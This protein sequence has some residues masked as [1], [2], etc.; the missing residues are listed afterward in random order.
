MGVRGQMATEPVR[1]RSAGI[2]LLAAG[3]VIVVLAI[4]TLAVVILEAFGICGPSSSLSPS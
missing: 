3:M 4:P 1:R 2:P